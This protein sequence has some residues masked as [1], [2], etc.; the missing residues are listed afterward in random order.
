MVHDIA[1]LAG[2]SRAPLRRLYR[3]RMPTER[4][5]TAELAARIARD[6]GAPLDRLLAEELGGNELTT[7]LLHALRTRARARDHRAVLEHARRAAMTHASGADPRRLHAFD[8]ALFGAARDFEAVELG[9]VVPLG[10]TAL[11]GVDPNN[12]LG[13]VRHVEVASDPATGLALHAARLR[14]DGRVD[15][16]RLAASQRVLRLQPF[17]VPGFSPHFRL[18]ALAT[19][20][21]AP[22]PHEALVEQLVAWADVV[23]AL[24]ASGFRTE[25]LRVVLADTRVVRAVLEARGADPDALARRAQA[26]R[27]GSTEEALAAA[28]L[29]P[30]RAI[31]DPVPALEALGV[32]PAIVAIAAELRDVVG[33]PLARARPEVPVAYDLGRLQGLL[34]YDGPFVQL[35]VRRDDGVELGLGDG[36]ALPW[37]GA[38]LDDRKERLVVTGV[39]AELIAKAF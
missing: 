21:R 14:K 29:A 35:H 1:P 9:P 32:P 37:L 30:P 28:G 10:A 6:A 4:D 33:N 16:L 24:R 3:R 8:G 12:V 7:L 18:A 13:A 26:H 20:S 19:A 27:P 34:Y 2:G 39:G 36:G 5:R 22:R 31:D 15:V 38:L 25:R 23:A 17:D 11:A